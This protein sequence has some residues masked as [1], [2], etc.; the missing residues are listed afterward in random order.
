VSR[1][2][3]SA[4]NASEMFMELEPRCAADPGPSRSVAVP[5]QRRTTSAHSAW[6]RLGGL[7]AL[8]L[9]RSRDTVAA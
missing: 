3:R 8:V 5:A 6:I 1:A 7:H 4:A 9:H 2:R